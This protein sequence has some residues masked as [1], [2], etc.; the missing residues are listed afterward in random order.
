MKHR[1]VFLFCVVFGIA[2]LAAAQS[3]VVT[4][5]DLD[6]Y[7]QKRLNAERDL[8]ENFEKMGFSS[9]QEL[10]LRREK[11]RIETEALAAKLRAE[12]LERDRI[13]AQ[14]QAEAVRAEAYY[15]SIQPVTQVR[16]DSGLY[17]WSYG[18]RYRRAYRPQQYQQPGY[19]AGGQF[20]PTGP[21]T[22][23]MPLFVT[24]RH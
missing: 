13:E 2:G 21:R 6:A 9:P 17:F 8:R 10:E 11:S 24:P 20:W 18:R 19:F 22:E 7:R 3:K 12:D 5:T 1:I 23:P 4:N 15:R 16:E 14:R